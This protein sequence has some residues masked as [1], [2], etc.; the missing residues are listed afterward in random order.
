VGKVRGNMDKGGVSREPG[1]FGSDPPDMRGGA[2]KT[3]KNDADPFRNSPR[4]D[5]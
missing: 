3:P 2:N 4:R 5:P 1:L